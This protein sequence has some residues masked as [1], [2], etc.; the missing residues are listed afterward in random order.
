MPSTVRLTGVLV[1]PDELV[2]INGNNTTAYLG[3]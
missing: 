3:T 1:V 2:T